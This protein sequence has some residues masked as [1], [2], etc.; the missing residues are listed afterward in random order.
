MVSP[1]FLRRFP[2]FG[3]LS[4]AQL[5]AVASL[6]E[7]KSYAKGATIFEE[8]DTADKLF[9]LLEG[10]VDLYYR[11]QEEYHPTTVKEFQVGEINVGEVFGTSSIIEPYELNATARAFEAARLVVINAVELRKLMGE[12]I[13]LTSKLYYQVIKSLKERIIALRVQLAAARP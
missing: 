13:S 9:L 4:E 6:A 5:K 3:A 7:E 8:C 12:D 10:N 11:S 2:F 1:E